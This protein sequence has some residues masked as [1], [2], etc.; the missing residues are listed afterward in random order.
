MR[1]ISRSQ[2]Q[3]LGMRHSTKQ[4]FALC[5]QY[6]QI[7]SEELSYKGPK[8]IVFGPKLSY[9]EF[10]MPFFTNFKKLTWQKNGLFCS[11]YRFSKTTIV[12]H[13]FRPKIIVQL[14][15]YRTFG[16]IAVVIIWLMHMLGL[17][18]LNLRFLPSTLVMYLLDRRIDVLVPV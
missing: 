3:R 1:D 10:F 16:N 5:A 7:F 13:F 12:F 2:G 4:T 6:C 11:N 9:F 14:S 8:I 15:Y 18:S 17:G